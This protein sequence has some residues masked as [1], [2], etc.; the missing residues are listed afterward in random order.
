MLIILFQLLMTSLYWKTQMLISWRI[1]RFSGFKWD[2]ILLEDTS[3]N[4]FDK[5]RWY[6][7]IKVIL[8][9]ILRCF[10]MVEKKPMQISF[11]INLKILKDV[12]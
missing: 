3:E 1:L 4:T 2:S 10:N 11:I 7:W 12:S 9:N 8:Q 6:I 5:T